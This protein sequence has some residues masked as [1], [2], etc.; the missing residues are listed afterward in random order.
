MRRT[1]HVLCAVVI[2]LS[3]LASRSAW[4]KGGPSEKEARRLITRMAGAS[5]PSGAV[6]IK[7]ITPV[8]DIEAVALAQV[9]TAFRLES[10]DDERWRVAEIRTGS[11]RWEDIS[12]LA[13]A[14]Q[15]GPAAAAASLEAG[16]PAAA[17]RPRAASSALDAPRAREVIARLLGIGLPSDAVRVKEVSPLYKSAVV[18]AQV[19]AEFRFQKGSDKKWRVAQVRTGGGE[20]A[21]V[22]MI[23]RTVNREKALRA[24]S[25][26]ELMA[27]ALDSFRRARGFYPAVDSTG[28]LIDQLNP[29]YLSRVI[30]L[31][32]WH[33]PYLYQGERDRYGL[34]SAGADGKPGTADDIELTGHA[35]AIGNIGR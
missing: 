5:L 12:L 3:P 27:A 24:R 1:A 15:G 20:W 6:R 34:R 32:P 23:V 4:A 29:R 25:E 13:L 22:E 2:C 31:D 16:T 11:D 30:R 35:Q 33:Q 19:A 14:A 21:D 28:A 10:D 17:M 26:L 18:V 7:T 8:S 9:E